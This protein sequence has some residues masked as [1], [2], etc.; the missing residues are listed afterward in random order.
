M[1]CW[2][3][4]QIGIKM[5]EQNRQKNIREQCHKTNSLWKVTV[6]LIKRQTV[7]NRCET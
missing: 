2:F 3:L 7:W 4:I 5:L 1:D 6:M